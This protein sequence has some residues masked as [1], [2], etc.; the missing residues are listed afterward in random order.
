MRTNVPQAYLAVVRWRLPRCDGQAL[1]V[2]R[3]HA[4]GVTEHMGELYLVDIGVPRSLEPGAVLGFETGP[5]FAT[6][7]AL[8]VG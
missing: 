2:E 6:P 4:D 1:P 8:R 7:D 5:V 3:I